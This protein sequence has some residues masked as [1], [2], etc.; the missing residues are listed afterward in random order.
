MT[1]LKAS[2]SLVIWV[3]SYPTSPIFTF[4]FSGTSK[5]FKHLSKVD[6]P[7]PEGPII[8]TVSPYSIEKEIPFK[9]SCCLNV[10][11]KSFTS[12]M[13]TPHLFVDVFQ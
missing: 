13:V 8:E 2:S 5:R 11:C 10:L 3:A 6:F 9:T 12:I 4:P 1:F 7:D